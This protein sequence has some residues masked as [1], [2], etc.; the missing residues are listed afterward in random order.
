MG[1]VYRVHHKNWNI[2]LAVKSPRAN[3][4]KTEVQKENFIKECETWI[5]LGLHPN[6]VSCYYVR[7]LGGIP[8]VF[9]EYVEG[10]SLKDWIDNK[11]LY[12]GGKEKALERI[13]DVSIQFA[14]GLHYSHEKD[15][16]HQDVKPANVMMTEDGTAK[17]TDFGLAKARA[18]AGE[19]GSGDAQQSILVSSGGMTPAYCSPEQANKQPLSRKTDIWSWGLSVL[20]MFAGEVFWRAGQI[21][22]DV[23]KSFLETDAEDDSIPKMLDAVVTLLRQCFQDNPDDRPNGMQEITGKLKEIYKQAVGQEYPRQAPKVTELFADNLNNKAVSLLDLGKKAEAE[24]LWHEALRLVPGHP[25]AMNN[26]LLYLE[27]DRSGYAPAQ[28]SFLLCQPF[29]AHVRNEVG[30]LNIHLANPD[31]IVKLGEAG[32]AAAIRLFREPK[33]LDGFV[34]LNQA[35]LACALVE[36]AKRGDR[37]AQDFLFDVAQGRVPIIMGSEGDAAFEIAQSYVYG[38]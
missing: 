32:L 9:A 4:F 2:D 20:E 24:K 22:Q 10:G 13:L 11:K 6:I 29:V 27:I 8:R 14:W 36:F 26:K 37:R 12:E 38:F 18:T 33:D 17:V 16:V 3:Y 15:L 7:T 1:L 30:N 35:V 5:N 21:A 25:E 19:D 28:Q 34:N 31:S 23:L